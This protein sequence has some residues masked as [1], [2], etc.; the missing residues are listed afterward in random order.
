VNQGL[1]GSP[2]QECADDIGIGNVG[3][4]IALPG[5]MSDVVTEGLMWLLPVVLEVPGVLRACVG[6]LKVPHEDLLQVCPILD[7][8]GWEVVQP[9]LGRVSQE[10]REV[11]D[12]E[13]VIIHTAGLTGK[14]VVLKP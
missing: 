13:V 9:C 11:A 7:G 2:R 8:V 12:D 14:P 5:E 3:Q 4:V 6:A 10:Q 1:I